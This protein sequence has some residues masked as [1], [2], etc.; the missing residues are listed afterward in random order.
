VAR[1]SVA[2]RLA[3]YV[4]SIY[5]RDVAPDLGVAC[6]FEPSCSNYA[7]QAYERHGALKATTKVVGRLRRCR[8]GYTGP[9]VDP[10]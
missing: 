1:P 9:F 10:P 8:P 4:V 6:P 2:G 3:R 5:Q 7:L